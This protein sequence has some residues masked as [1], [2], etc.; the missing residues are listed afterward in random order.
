M[1]SKKFLQVGANNLKCL[2]TT[3]SYNFL[4]TSI[5]KLVFK[6]AKT[7]IIVIYSLSCRVYSEVIKCVKC[8]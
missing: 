5:D 1:Y 4:A 8:Q 6:K 2:D 7:K 3:E